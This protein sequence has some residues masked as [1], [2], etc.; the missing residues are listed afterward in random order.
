MSIPFYIN[1]A[2]G[3][4]ELTADPSP[5][6]ESLGKRFNLDQISTRAKTL[7]PT[8]SYA[9]KPTYNWEEGDWWDLDDQSVGNTKIL[10]D[11][12][13]TEEMRRR[14]N[15]EGGRIGLAQGTPLYTA[16]ADNFKLL[17]NLILNTKKTLNEIKAAFGGNPKAGN[18]GIN[19]LIKAWSG[20]SKDRVVPKDRFKYYK[21]T[22]DSPKVK[23]VIGLFENGMSKKAIEF[24]TGI[25]RKEIRNIFHKFKPEYIGDENLPKGEGRWGIQKRRLKIIKELTDYW[26]DKPGG[27]KML[28]EL[29]TKLRE[30]K[31]KNAEILTMSDKAI[32]NN[33]KFKEAMNLDVKGLKAGKGINF[34]RYKNL[35][36]AEYI[37]KV[38]AMAETNQFYQPEHF[39]AINKKNPASM[40]PKNIYTAVGKM[41]GQ[42][43]VMK[44]LI[45]NNPNDKRVSDIIK[46][47]KSQNLPIPKT[48]TSAI[49]KVGSKIMTGAE[50]V[51]RPLFV[52]AVDAAVGVKDPSD[53][54][55][56]MSKA[57]WAHAMDKYGITKTHDMLKKTPDFKGKA[58]ILRDMSLRMGLTPNVV[59]GVSKVS[60]P[61]TAYASLAKWQS[62][63][64]MKTS[65]KAEELGID[66]SQYVDRTGG[67]IDFTDELYEEI[68]KRESGKGM[69]YA[70]GGIASLIK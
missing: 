57:F 24:E 34:N 43:E 15:A 47:F 9:E 39:I 29:T 10:E 26:K 2:T 46:L 4:L 18:Q 58:K 66:V 12:E 25:S 42:M 70:T 5:L 60:W 3:E 49:K 65:K 8:K 69:D 50:K 68:A 63:P 27:K 44:N 19:K 40:N 38:K 7:S 17:D 54:F 1:P 23:E 36:D 62:E 16:T 55:F 6:R 53:P 51:F 28:E 59:R 30:I 14:P 21:F 52:P 56:W 37:A 11:F 64:F 22:A 67:V 41:G 31:L 48:E 61:L 32:L 20:S 13:I 45:N 33:E 35:T